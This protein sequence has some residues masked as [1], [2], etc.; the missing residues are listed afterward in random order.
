VTDETLDDIFDLVFLS[1][2]RGGDSRR[3]FVVDGIVYSTPSID[4]LTVRPMF[5]LLPDHEC[6]LFCPGRWTDE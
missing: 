3:A 2:L 4:D 6:G 5:E 1:A